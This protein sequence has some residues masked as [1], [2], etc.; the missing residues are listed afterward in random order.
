MNNKQNN[1]VPNRSDTPVPTP[2]PMQFLARPDIQTLF[3]DKFVFTKR[4][5]RTLIASGI[6]GVPGM[7]IEQLRFLITEDHAKNFLDILAKLLDYYPAKEAKQ[8]V[9]VKQNTKPPASKKKTAAKQTKMVAQK[10]QKS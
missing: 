9:P 1:P 2:P 7:E 4:P 6:Q 5:D 10:K 3:I 8:E